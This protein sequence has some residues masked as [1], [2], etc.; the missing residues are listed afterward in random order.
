M[1]SRFSTQLR[2]LLKGHVL[3]W[4]WRSRLERRRVRGLATRDAVCRY[5]ERFDF[6]SCRL[7]GE[8]PVAADPCRERI[9]SIWLQGEDKAPAIVQACWRSVRANC[10][11]ELVILDADT[12]FDW[13]ELPSYVV[14]KWKSG[15]MRHAHFTDICRVALLYRHGGLWLDSTDFVTAPIPGWILGQDFFV[16]M[17]GENQ[18]GFYSYIQNCFIRGRKGNYLLKSWLG[19]M[20]TYWR[21]EDDVIDYFVHQLLFR[22]VVEHD[23]SAAELFRLMPK[24]CQDPTHTLWF[25][26]ADRP[27]DSALFEELTSGA[28]FQKTEYKSSSARNPIPGSFADMMQ[29]MFL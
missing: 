15:K 11:E 16:Y 13:I 18:R 6:S 23:K 9:F 5:L 4:P 27:F 29:K 10:R 14:D 17:S 1:S 20:F 28:A 2:I 8:L 21:E 12:V 3:N 22:K 19:A 7:E 26:N 25:G 24:V